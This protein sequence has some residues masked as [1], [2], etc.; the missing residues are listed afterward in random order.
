MHERRA[1]RRLAQLVHV[2]C[3]KHITNGSTSDGTTLRR[4]PGGSDCTSHHAQGTA[5]SSQPIASSGTAS[6][7][8]TASGLTASGCTSHHA[9]QGTALSQ[10]PISGAASSGLTASGATAS[11]T[12]S[13]AVTPFDAP[14]ADPAVVA[15]HVDRHGYCV[16]VGALSPAELAHVNG[17]VDDSL[18]RIPMTWSMIASGGLAGARAEYMHPL[19]DDHGAALDG[20]TR[21]ANI[22]PVAQALLGGEACFTQFDFRQSPGGLELRN[23]LHHDVGS[24]R[25]SAAETIAARPFGRHDTLCSIVYLTDVDGTT[26]AFSVVPGSHRVPVW[27]APGAPQRSAEE[28]AAMYEQCMASGG[29]ALWRTDSEEKQVREALG[30]DDAMA[31]VRLHAPAGSCVIYDVSLFHGRAAGGD[32]QSTRRTMHQYYGRQSGAPNIPWNLLPQRLYEHPDPK[33]RSFYSNVT[34]VQA[35][36]AESGYDLNVCATSPALLAHLASMRGGR[37]G[38][39]GE[40]AEGTAGWR[41]LGQHGPAHLLDQSPVATVR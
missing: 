15:A 32:A 24:A 2:L 1:A 4:Q 25:T 6:S 27:P 19:L 33:I 17:W 31:A 34:P 37:G 3:G 28:D 12:A 22:L 13:D 14:S 5:A 29:V 10:R 9:A 20:Y 16:L 23:D 21:H 40:E 30:S 35:A 39:G 11:G 18:A 8:L 26:P 38:G 7:G 41:F 36:F